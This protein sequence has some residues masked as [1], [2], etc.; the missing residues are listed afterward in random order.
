MVGAILGMVPVGGTLRGVLLVSKTLE[1][2]LVGGTLG[3]KVTEKT[4]GIV[5]VGCIFCVVAGTVEEEMLIV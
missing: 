4:S 1:M 5:A 3:V 2:I